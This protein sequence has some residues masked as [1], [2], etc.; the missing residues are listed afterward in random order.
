MPTGIW[1][2]TREAVKTAL[3]ELETARSNDA[4]DEA[5]E[6]GARDVDGFCLQPV[7]GM[8]PLLAT[9]TFDYPARNRRGSANVIRFDGAQLISATLITSAG[10]TV[11]L[12]SGDYILEPRNQPPYT[13]LAINLGSS[14]TFDSGDTYQRAIGITGLWGWS[15]D[16]R[17]VGSLSS[18]L[19]AST[20][21]TA[22]LAWTTARFG[23]GTVLQIDSERMVITDRNFVDSA[24]NLGGNLAA[25]MT[26]TQVSVGL[27]SAFA[28][29]EIISIDGERMRIVDITGNTATVFRAW[30]GSQLA[31]HTA[32]AD[33]YALTG[34]TLDRAVL[35]TT[36]AAHSSSVA[37]YAWRPHA[38][39]AEL[40]RA[41]AINTLLQGRAGYA[42]VAGTGENAREFT[43]RGIAQ[44]E[45]DVRAVFVPQVRH[46][47]I[48]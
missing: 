45:D 16:V 42:R 5:V 46:R 34:V 30:D 15:N 36:L 31:A 33:I 37:V 20:S 43:G 26:D 8:A 22:S 2:T 1:Y 44:I 18:S 11:T 17:S 27:G 19:A 25:D 9:K 40:N 39:L 38:L 29:E 6:A 47:A 24:Q 48:T 21:A 32:G 12:T 41:Y 7:D 35:G 4:I 10:G 13:S 3:D 23:A 28:V 14:A